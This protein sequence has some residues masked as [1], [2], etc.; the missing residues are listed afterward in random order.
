MKVL[1]LEYIT[2]GGMV[3]SVLPE[4]LVAEARIMLSAVISDLL[5]INQ[6]ELRVLCDSRLLKQ[7]PAV[8]CSGYECVPVTKAQGFDAIWKETIDRVDAV[9]IIAPETDGT[10]EYLCATVEASGTLLLNCS[11]QAVKIAASKLETYHRLLANDIPVLPTCRLNAWRLNDESQFTFPQVV[12]P[13]DG[14]GCE[15]MTVVS[16]KQ[17]LDLLI[18]SLNPGNFIVQPWVAG[19]AASL[20]VIYDQRDAYLL[21]Y[22]QQL[23][24]VKQDRIRLAGCRVGVYTECWGFYQALVLRI[25]ECLH[26]LRGYVGIDIIETADGPMVVEINPRL[27]T[28]YAGISRAMGVNPAEMILKSFG[29]LS[30]R[31]VVK[32]E[33]LQCQSILI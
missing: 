32:P 13:D 28:S 9:F 26:G 5:A 16:D 8:E 6:L 3:D 22:N 4:S 12:K 21:T 2:G 7:T 1:V 27:T 15:A 23:I 29:T 25:A 11:S 19:Q 31:S 33:R 20:S 14:V 24:E 17:S 18:K 10:L 30:S